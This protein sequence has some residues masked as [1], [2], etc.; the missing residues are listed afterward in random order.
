MTR[1][2][3]VLAP[4]LALFAL[5]PASAAL[6]LPLGDGL[7]CVLAFEPDPTPPPVIVRPWT[8]PPPPTV[9]IRPWTPPPQ[10]VYVRPWTPP[11]P[12]V[13]SYA[14]PPPARV[15]VRSILISRPVTPTVVVSEPA[16][17]TA[18]ATVTAVD[19][20]GGTIDDRGEGV[21][22]ARRVVVGAGFGGL[23]L[24]GHDSS[25]LS[26]SFA[27]HLAVALRQASV[28]LRVDM[29]P[30]AVEVANGSG[31]TSP[32]SYTIGGLGFGYHFNADS[33]IHPVV[34]A[35]L[36]LHALDPQGADASFGFGLGARAGLEMEY[37]LDS[38]SLGIGVDVSGHRRFGSTHAMPVPA[39]ALA[40]GGTIDYRF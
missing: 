19:E 32:A 17:A 9:V 21:R 37:P 34:G 14:V 25:T 26:P 40:F 20:E 16:P 35:S 12:P 22:A 36:E 15:Y 13:T 31:G 39:T 10:R 7:P 2:I 6:A 4:S 8:P 38:G 24:T 18:T 30:D 29:A 27:L 1:P 23:M 28:G 3:H 33:L 5:F 11:P